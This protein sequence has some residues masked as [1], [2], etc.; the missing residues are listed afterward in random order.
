MNI[1]VTGGAG[2]IG[3][4]VVEQLL[5]RDYR[6]V[7]IDNLQEGNREAILPEA[8]FYE[9]DFGNRDVLEDVF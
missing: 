1:L 6:V 4:I 7:V 5:E 8:I 2:Y 9:A 3:S